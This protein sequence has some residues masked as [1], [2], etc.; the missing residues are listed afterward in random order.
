MLSAKWKSL[1]LPL[2]NAGLLTCFLILTYLS[3]VQ[4]RRLSSQQMAKRWEAGDTPY[5]QVSVFL[6]PQQFMR[7]DRV[8]EI[9]S[10]LMGKLSKDSYDVRQETPRLWIDS[11]FGECPL[12]VRRENKTQSVT[13]A[14]VGGDFFQFHPMEL[15]S[16]S[17]ISGQDVNRDRIVVDR[18]FAWNMFGSNDIVGMQVMVNETY[19]TIVGVV[20]AEED[21]LSAAAYG[22][23]CRIYMLY[24][25]L[26][27]QASEVTITCYEAVLPNPIS[28][29][30]ANAVKS[31]FD[32]P[33]EEE[34]SEKKKNPINF[35]DLEI[36]EN[37]SRFQLFPLLTQIREHRFRSMRANHIA[38][39]FWENVARVAEERQCSLLLW[40]M[41][42]LVLPCFT[43]AWLCGRLWKRRTWTLRSLVFGLFDNIRERSAQKAWRKRMEAGEQEKEGVSDVEDGEEAADSA[44]E[45]GDTELDWKD[46]DP[47]EPDREEEEPDPEEQDRE[48]A[49]EN[50]DGAV[51]AVTGEDIFS[52][53]P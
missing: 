20:A 5:A 30:A 25:E 13:A 3:G 48:E 34:N 15:L 33:E 43:L 4:V 42:L 10:S 44:L 31:A 6:A 28:N 29:Y 21:R 2:I 16:G 22:N 36:V 37:T 17:Y 19:Y 51:Y 49:S 47:E 52:E 1:L 7:E 14:G 26:V 23:S 24:D 38:Y 9:R 46:T 50:P 8:G 12:T 40:R 32:L 39:P 18:D 53:K 27:K 41:L 11:Y 35:D 45:D